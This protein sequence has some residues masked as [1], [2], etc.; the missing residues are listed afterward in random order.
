M[1]LGRVW[2]PRL[3]QS[4]IRIY[5]AQDCAV[6]IATR[7]VLP[8]RFNVLRSSRFELTSMFTYTI[9]IKTQDKYRLHQLKL[10]DVGLLSPQTATCGPILSSLDARQ[11]RP[12]AVFP[13]YPWALET[14]RE[15]AT[16][17]Y[18]ALRRADL[19]ENHNHTRHW[20][21]VR[22]TWRSGKTRTVME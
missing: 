22:L 7:N 16:E 17:S 14:T 1:Q 8:S 19:L 20:S 13:K 2:C 10:F 12:R 3:S 5:G 21:M 4:A 9:H 6:T 18:R 15:A 11:N